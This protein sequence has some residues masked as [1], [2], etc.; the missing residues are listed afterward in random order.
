MKDEISDSWP[1][2]Y[3]LASQIGQIDL[4]ASR[5]RGGKN[6]P[7]STKGLTPVPFPK[8]EGYFNATPEQVAS[9]RV[10][11]IEV[12]GDIRGFQREK[13]NAHARKIAKAMLE[14]EEM[15]PIIVSLFPDGNAYVDD[16]QHR[17]LGAVIARKPI[18]VV[19]KRRSVEQARRLFANQGR[20]KKVSHNDT[21]LTGDSAIEI[22]IQDA[23]TRDDHPWSDLVAPYS[24]DRK[25]TPTSMAIIVGAFSYNAINQGVNFYVEK[26]RQEFNHEM[27]DALAALI[28]CFGHKGTNPLAFRARSLR[29]I[30]YAAIHI[31]RRNP[32][33]QDKDWAR[34]AKHMPTFD[35]AKY[36]HLL[37]KEG[38][39]SQILIEHWNKR[40][41]EARKVRPWTFN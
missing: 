10:P 11:K 27:A 39:L 19:V 23:V 15:P 18:E 28:R 36:P 5:F 29:A 41:P 31:F 22:Y 37:N 32:G 30:A 21:L 24:S 33:V 16:G 8:R 17:A 4:E 25:M 12:N 14:G 26:S 13:V 6:R 34:W 2:I 7:P 35:F 3:E 1:T 9:L 38:E 40:L 20:A